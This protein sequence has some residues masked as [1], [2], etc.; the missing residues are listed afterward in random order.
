MKMHR[1]TL[2][3]IAGITTLALAIPI[4]AQVSSATTSETGSSVARSRPIPTQ[5]QVQEMVAKDDAFLKNIDAMV[6]IQKSA[7]QAHETALTAAASITDD[8][9]RDTAVQKANEDERS[10]IQN[11]ITANPDLKSAMMPFGGGHGFGGR[12]MMGRGPEADDLATKLGMTETDLKAALDSGKTI[13]QIATEKGVTLPEKK[14]G[15][16]GGWMMDRE[17][18]DED[19]SSSTSSAQ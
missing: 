5:Q 19:A 10:A 17:S 3:A 9:Q 8:A 2:G 16:H 7:I 12:G 6:T 1:F 18:P 13:E 15:K 11:A 4:L 14:E